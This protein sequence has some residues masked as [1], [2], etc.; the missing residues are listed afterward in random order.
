MTE[1]TRIVY[2]NICRGLFNAHKLIFS[3][4]IGSRIALKAKTISP[5]EWDLFLKGVIIDG[6]IKNISNPNSD[7]I[8]DKAWRFIL[9][10]EPTSEAFN[11]FPDSIVKNFEQW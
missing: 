6:D 4:L 7:I 1:I 9:N 10:L 2:Q 8:T 11:G 3:F 5:G